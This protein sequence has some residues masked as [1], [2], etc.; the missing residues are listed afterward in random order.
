MGQRGLIRNIAERFTGRQDD[1]IDGGADRSRVGISPRRGPVPDM[2]VIDRADGPAVLENEPAQ[3]RPD[4]FRSDASGY[5]DQPNVEPG[6]TRNLVA[7]WKNKE[8]ENNSPQVN[9]TK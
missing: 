9:N 8:I 3:L 6:T 7:S 4:V 1:S 5:L 2:V